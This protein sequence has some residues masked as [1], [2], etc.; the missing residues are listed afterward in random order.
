MTVTLISSLLTPLEGFAFKRICFNF[1]L[2]IQFA[3][4]PATEF[5][6]C[7]S[8]VLFFACKR[9][10]AHKSAHGNEP[11]HWVQV[12]DSRSTERGARTDA[13][14]QQL[15]LK[16]HLEWTLNS[17]P[18]LQSLKYC[19]WTLNKQSEFRSQILLKEI[20]PEST[21]VFLILKKKIIWV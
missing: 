18:T 7:T 6:V 2:K 3:N 21:N 19:V 1:P 10:P 4:T 5:S 11:H 8:Q 16:V 12:T 14:I 9:V 17:R 15:R 13:I 20:C